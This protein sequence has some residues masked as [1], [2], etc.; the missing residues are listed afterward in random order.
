M[1]GE[2]QALKWNS[3]FPLTSLTSSPVHPVHLVR[4]LPAKL[5]WH[6]LPIPLLPLLEV[7]TSFSM[8]QM[9]F[10]PGGC[11]RGEAE[12]YH[13]SQDVAGVGLAAIWEPHCSLSSEISPND[14]GRLLQQL[15]LVTSSHRG[16]MQEKQ[17]IRASFSERFARQ[18]GP[19]KK[20]VWED[21]SQGA[22]GRSP[23]SYRP[24]CP[25]K[26]NSW[27]WLDLWTARHN[28]PKAHGSPQLT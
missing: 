28:P 15:W 7:S 3:P 12:P 4:P 16:G 18:P 2:I 17:P 23:W 14:G 10:S 19:C 6:L 24:L 5:W 25:Y 11:C 20:R 8:Q 26:E 1:S 9:T 27:A 13:F 22:G 21:G